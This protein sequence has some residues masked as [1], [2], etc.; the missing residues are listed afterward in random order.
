MI[1]RGIIR[2]CKCV[3]WPGRKYSLCHRSGFYQA[4][5][6][7]NCDWHVLLI[8]RPLLTS[9]SCV[10]RCGP[11]RQ[12]L[13]SG[14]QND[15]EVTRKQTCLIGRKDHPALRGSSHGVL[16]LSFPA[17]TLVGSYK[18]LKVFEPKPSNFLSDTTGCL[19][20]P[21]EQPG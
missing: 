19:P 13:C 10:S 1:L 14:I 18:W 2:T 12:H 15:F 4:S 5:L 11:S 3:G 7:H 9:P 20:G 16:Q 6:H 21:R 17:Y 8:T